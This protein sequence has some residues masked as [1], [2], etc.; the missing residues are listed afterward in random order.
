[1][2]EKTEIVPAAD[3]EFEDLTMEFLATQYAIHPV[4]AT[5]KGVHEYDEALDSFQR[6]AIR[7]DRD[8]VRAYLHAIDKI[9]LADLSFEM[10]VDYRVARSSAQMTL[11]ALEHQRWPET[12]PDRYFDMVL[13]GLALLIDRQCDPAEVRALGLLGR[14]RALPIA[15]TEARN[16][17]KKPPRLFIEVALEQA[18]AGDLLF[19][20]SLP[21]FISSLRDVPLKN[22]LNNAAQPARAALTDF[23]Q[24]IR[25][26]LHP[27][28][29]ENF[30]L[31]KERYDYFLRVGHLMPETSEELLAIGQEEIT[32]ARKELAE[33]SERIE[34]GSAWETQFAG[35]KKSHPKPA[36]LT[37]AYAQEVVKAK[38]FIEYHRLMAL[39]TDEALQVETTPNWARSATPAPTY[40][41]A[42]PFEEQQSGQLWI[43]PPTKGL[44][45]KLRE[46]ELQEHSRYQIPL[47]ALH[48]GYPGRHL[49]TGRANQTASRFRRHFA[50]SGLFTEGWAAYC[51]GMMWEHGYFNDPRIHLMQIRRQLE[52]ACL[53][54]LDV[55]I[56]TRGKSLSDAAQFLQETAKTGWA[57]AR[58]E[59]RRCAL[60]PTQGV[61]STMGCRSLLALRDEMMRRQG[62]RFTARRFHDRI[63]A[64]GSIQPSLL[65]EVMFAVR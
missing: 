52:R 28:A 4:M 24:Y 3:R 60:F 41:P 46:L 57:A 26:T 13:S 50:E 45:P 65:P 36:E 64:E 39:P 51:E 59:T 47:T 32:Q 55:E 19:T 34:P 8:Q 16:N 61:M 56:H 54:V 40:R 10:R 6:F 27:N 53:L 1:M 31:G 58:M 37:E 33:I 11:A 63:L 9:S 43:A 44:P 21:V 18:A 42:A 25:E 7:D 30:A 2:D 48:E 38:D 20:D 35:L 29:V 14:L 23:G 15:L 17:L 12:R 49:Q 5:R 62:A 22:A